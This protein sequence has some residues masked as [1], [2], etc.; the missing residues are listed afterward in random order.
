M[1]HPYPESN[2]STDL[3]PEPPAPSEESAFWR[4]LPQLLRWIG[5]LSLF[6]SALA[7]LMGGW[8][9]AEPLFRY[10]SFFALTSALA[11]AGVFCGLRLREDKGARTFLSLAAAFI[12]VL[13]CQLGAMVYAEFAGSA[14][15]FSEYMRLFQ[16]DPIGVP[17]LAATVAISLALLGLYAYL[18]F[19]AMARSAAKPLTLVYLAGN[20]TLLL[21]FRNEAVIAAIAFALLLALAAID[22]K[23]FAPQSVLRTWDGRAM[24]SLLFAPFILL[25]L[26]NA[27]LHDVSSLMLSLFSGAIAAFCFLA[28][29]PLSNRNAVKRFFQHCAIPPLFIAVLTLA[30]ALVGIGSSRWVD[31]VITF[32]ILP[33][34]ALLALFSRYTCDSGRSFRLIAA[35]TAV[36]ASFLQMNDVSG[37]LPAAIAI[38]V[39]V[40]TLAAS[41]PLR[42]KGLLALGLIGT[43]ASLLYHVGYAAT[44][45]QANLWLSLAATGVAVILVASYFERHWQA[46]ISR[47][48]TFRHALASWR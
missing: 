3:P 23:R 13:F 28:L 5:G 30:E 29:P 36:G 1:N 11:A 34:A 4:R 8:M 40:A 2:A 19:S 33:F 41:Y 12:P 6:G 16:F 31:S 20:A 18:G 42:E 47:G 21:P 45:Y 26:R 15:Q 22:R 48:K 38:A 27:L 46:L 10:Y 39:S 14:S 37:A 7:F 32:A 9:N 24:R 17:L 43:L 35:A 25:V 44:L